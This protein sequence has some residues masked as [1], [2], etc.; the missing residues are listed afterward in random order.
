M[1]EN[2]IPCAGVY[3]L[4][5]QSNTRDLHYESSDQCYHPCLEQPCPDRY[6]KFDSDDTTDK[7]FKPRSIQAAWIL[8]STPNPTNEWI[9]DL[10]S[11]HNSDNE[12]D[13]E[14][15]PLDDPNDHTITL[16]QA[17]D[18][19]TDMSATMTVTTTGQAAAPAPPTGNPPAPP[20]GP[21]GGPPAPP[22]GGPPGPPPGPRATR[23]TT[24]WASSRTSGPSPSLS[25][26]SRYPGSRYPDANSH[27]RHDYA[28]PRGHPTTK[29][30]AGP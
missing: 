12:E 23:R 10:A 19:N 26:R 3:H 4:F 2:H 7:L 28:Y 22:P 13:E 9:R 1:D 14:D 8:E 29:P 5:D 24:R 20:A 15:D 25:H 18:S 21:P 30:A 27:D 11:N 17:P 6:K 16:D